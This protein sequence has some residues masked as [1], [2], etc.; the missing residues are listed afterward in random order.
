MHAQRFLLAISLA[1]PLIAAAQEDS[2]FKT[3]LTEGVAAL[4]DAGWSIPKEGVTETDGAIQITA[5]DGKRQ[6][7]TFDLPVEKGVSYGGSIMVKSVDVRLRNNNDR[8]A[9]FFFGM[10]TADRKWV[11]GGEFPRGPFG[12][13]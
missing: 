9:T 12:E 2:V 10:L 1:F 6:Y 11:N 13:K 3:P 7:M 8:G 4:R 5:A